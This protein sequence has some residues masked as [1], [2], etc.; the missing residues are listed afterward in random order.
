ML[1][2]EQAE[3]YAKALEVQAAALRESEE[4]FRS[5][6]DYAPPCGL[7]PS[8]NRWREDLGAPRGAAVKTGPVWRR[9]FADGIVLVNPSPAATATVPLGGSYVDRTG[10]VVTSAVVPPHTGVMLRRR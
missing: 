3:E 10:S 5:A 6:F 7:E 2:A 9:V 4:R 1:Q 8:S